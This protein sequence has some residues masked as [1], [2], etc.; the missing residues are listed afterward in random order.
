MLDDDTWRDAHIN[1]AAALV[2]EKSPIEL[3]SR[4]YPV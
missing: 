3:E 1:L 4:T 2:E